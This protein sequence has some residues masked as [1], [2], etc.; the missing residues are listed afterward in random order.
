MTKVP[1]IFGKVREWHMTD[2][3]VRQFG[4][5]QHIPDNVEYS[6]DHF[7]PDNR[8]TITSEREQML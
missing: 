3:V 1:L 6:M 4:F 5:P 8:T 2:R 7:K